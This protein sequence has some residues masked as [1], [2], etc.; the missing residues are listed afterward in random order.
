MRVDADT[1]SPDLP[2]SVDVPTAEKRFISFAV[3]N[4]KK[5][6]AVGSNNKKGFLAVM[7]LNTGRILLEKEFPDAQEF[8]S[9]AFTPDGSMVFLTNRN[10]RVYGLDAASGELKHEWI[11]LKPGQKNA[12]TNETRSDSITISADGRYV[13][14]VVINLAHVWDAETGEHIF[15]CSPGHKLTGAIA[16]SPDGSV[17]ATSDIRASGSIRLWHVK[18]K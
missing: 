18:K 16:L 12:V 7:D 6:I 8:T 2:A 14:A 10:G 1:L 3:S 9:A 13:A 5:A 4:D 15:Q 11:V 17:L